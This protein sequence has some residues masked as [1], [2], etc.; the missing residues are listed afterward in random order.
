MSVET[1]LSDQAQFNENHEK[2]TLQ[3]Y[4]VF[5]A[6]CQTACS[7]VYGSRDIVLSVETPTSDQAQFKENPPKK[8]CINIKCIFLVVPDSLF[9]VLWIRRHSRV[10]RNSNLWSGTFKENP[11]KTHCI[12]VS[13]AW[14]QAAWRTE[15]YGSRDMNHDMTNQLIECTH[16]E[17]S[18]QTGNPPSLIKVLAR[19][20]I[21][22]HGLNDSL[23]GQRRL[24]SDWVEAHFH[25][26][27]RRA[28]M[29]SCTFAVCERE[30]ERERDRER[31][32]ERERERKRE[33]ELVDFLQ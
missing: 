2:K 29:P 25:L 5:S 7:G 14:C 16:S 21:F 11:K 28:D 17:D 10:S 12:I 19:R 8:H 1:S 32:R 13:S 33:R 3:Y 6:W 23:Y 18:D 22:S 15:F 4:S 26:C 30:R 24:W 31:E 20:S 27:R 9:W